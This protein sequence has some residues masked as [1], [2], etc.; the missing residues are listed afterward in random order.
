MECCIVVL[1]LF[2]LSIELAVRKTLSK[3]FKYWN[4]TTGT[5]TQHANTE[6]HRNA[7]AKKVEL[8]AKYES[9]SQA[10]DTVLSRQISNTMET[11]KSLLRI[12][13]LCGKQ[14]LALRGHR[15][16]RIDWESVE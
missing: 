5:A 10:V 13:L 9:P 7:M 11:N 6:Y 16:N 14:G 3:P 2:Y 12:I 8:L 15:N 1:V 4:K